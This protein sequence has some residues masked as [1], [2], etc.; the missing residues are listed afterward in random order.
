M[1]PLL[2][3]PPG[4]GRLHELAADSL[5]AFFA[6]SI[7]ADFEADHEPCGRDQ[8]VGALSQEASGMTGKMPAD[9]G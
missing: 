1:A 8:V 5:S 3:S 6:A 7:I 9:A 2:G 4:Q